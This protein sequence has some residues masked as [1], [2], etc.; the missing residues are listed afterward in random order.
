MLHNRKMRSEAVE[1]IHHKLDGEIS[2]VTMDCPS[3]HKDDLLEDEDNEMS[4]NESVGTQ[5]EEV[6]ES[7]TYLHVTFP[8][9]LYC[10]KE[11]DNKLSGE[12]LGKKLEK[13][14]KLSELQLQSLNTSTHQLRATCFGQD[15]YWRR[16]WSLPKAGGVFVEAMES[17]QPEVLDE[18]MDDVAEDKLSELNTK[19]IDDIKNIIIHDVDALSD[20][21]TD[22]KEVNLMEGD[23]GGDNTEVVQPTMSDNNECKYPD[24][25]MQLTLVENG[26]AMDSGERNLDELRKSVDRIVQSLECGDKKCVESQETDEHVSAEDEIKTEIKSEL[27]N[28]Q[29]SNRKFNLFEKLGECMER[30]NKTEEDLKSEV[31]A[32][33]KEELK[34]E[35]LNELKTD[36]KSETR[37]EKLGYEHGG[38]E[39][40]EKK[41]FSILTKERQTTCKGVYLT[42][43]NKWDNGVGACTRDNLTELKIPVFPPPNSS[44]LYVPTTCDSPGP[45]QMTAEENAQ[46]EYIK[47]HGLPTSCERKPVPVDKRYGWWKITDPEQLKD[48]LANLH[49]RGVR[50]RELKRN[51]MSVMNLMYEDQEKIHIEEGQKELTELSTSINTVPEGSGVPTA[52]HSNS[53]SPAVANRV[54]L[55]LLEQVILIFTCKFSCTIP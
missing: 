9:C 13:F 40:S 53:W 23:A 45:L 37:G 33:V 44:S 51:F 18:Q 31:K 55:A 46:M 28:E 36:I 30:E 3:L 39:D 41:W 43:G 21:G 11:E 35:I 7:R 10:F 4:E 48:I 50:E 6:F 20:T 54:D 52:D 5:P 26:D 14:T 19:T 22:N 24:T 29:I 8:S 2:D 16:Y 49:V 1:K 25:S 38:D 47:V 32:E 27:E 17:S 12:E 15:R 34:N 42:A